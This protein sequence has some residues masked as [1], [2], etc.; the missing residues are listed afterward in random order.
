MR[1]EFHCQECGNVWL[2]IRPVRYRKR[3]AGC[4]KCGSKKTHRAEFCV[5][6]KLN[7]GKG[8]RIPGI[9]HTIDEKPIYVRSK[10][11]F[12][13]LCKARNLTPVNL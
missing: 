13:E 6:I 7:V 5:G 11:H 9:C 3:P 1:Y 10:S 2:E 8:S 12:K 4:I